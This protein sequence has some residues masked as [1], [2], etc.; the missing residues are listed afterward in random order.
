M[1]KTGA[2]HP[3]LNCGNVKFFNVL[4]PPLAEQRRI[5]DY[6]DDQRTKLENMTAKVADSIAR[7]QEYRSVLITAAV[8]GQ[9]DGLQ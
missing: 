8:T 4:I 5:A 7:L 9:I 1:V 3:H 6:V 2:L